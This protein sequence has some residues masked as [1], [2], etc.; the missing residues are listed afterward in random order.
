MNTHFRNLITRVFRT[1]VIRRAGYAVLTV[2]IAFC[3]STTALASGA[4]PMHFSHILLEDGLS[5]NNVQSILQDSQGY[6]W[7]A[8]ENG[9]NRYDGY[10][11]RQYIGCQRG[12]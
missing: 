3:T 1:G 7:F 10:N 5:Q 8:T 6:M 4:V 2:A 11:I 12:Q 9:L